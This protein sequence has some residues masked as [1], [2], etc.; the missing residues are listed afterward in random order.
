MMMVDAAIADDYVTLSTEQMSFTTPA[1]DAA[2]R[3]A[4]SY[5]DFAA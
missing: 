4:A 5:F 3:A 2:F 1:A